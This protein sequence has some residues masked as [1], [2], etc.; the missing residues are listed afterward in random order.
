MDRFP[1]HYTRCGLDSQVLH[2]PIPIIGAEFPRFTQFT[3]ILSDK[4]LGFSKNRS[5]LTTSVCDLSPVLVPS[6]VCSCLAW[7]AE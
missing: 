4:L 7:I 2:S 1:S 5:F 6:G 3:T